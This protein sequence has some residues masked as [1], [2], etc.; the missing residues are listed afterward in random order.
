MH[1]LGIFSSIPQRLLGSSQFTLHEAFQQARTIEQ[2]KKPSASNENN[3]VA[4]AAKCKLD[5]LKPDQNT[6]AAVP[7]KSNRETQENCYFYGNS[8]HQHSNCPACNYECRK[9]K[10]T[11]HWT[12]VC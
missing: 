3:I 7:K 1:L 9:Y 2:G 6:I 4:A 11:G 8:R 5:N 12:K 10:K